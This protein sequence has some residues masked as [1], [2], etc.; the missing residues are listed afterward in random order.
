QRF[1]HPT[2]RPP[3]QPRRPVIMRA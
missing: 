3:P 2:Y 1:I